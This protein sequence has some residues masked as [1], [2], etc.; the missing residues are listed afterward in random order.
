MDKR[1]KTP[2]E[3]LYSLKILETMHYENCDI[4]RVHKGWIFTI[5]TLTNDMDI[6]V[7]SVFVP[8]K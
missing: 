2:E 1:E 4:I 8:K 6:K 7:S 5:R 3:M